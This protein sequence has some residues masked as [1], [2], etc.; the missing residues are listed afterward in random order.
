MRL[1]ILPPVSLGLTILT[2][3]ASSAAHHSFAG[4]FD[5]SHALHLQGVV[6]SVEMVNPHSYIHLEVRTAEGGV[7]RWALEGP[8]ALSIRRRGLDLQMVKSGDALGVCG[9]AARRDVTLG[10]TAQAADRSTRKLSAAVLTLPGGKQRVWE[11]YRQGKCVL[12]R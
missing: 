5:A 12:D 3:T 1:R 2:M 7:E 11:N 6:A 4:E 9:Y 8:S 10:R